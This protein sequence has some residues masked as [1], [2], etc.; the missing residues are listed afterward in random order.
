MTQITYIA[1]ERPDRR[2]SDR[3][4]SPRHYN[5]V[6]DGVCISDVAVERHDVNNEYT[7]ARSRNIMCGGCITLISLCLVGKARIAGSEI[8]L[9]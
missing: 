4:N 1:F 8:L 7:D 2:Q 6:L 5:V 9:L 3:L